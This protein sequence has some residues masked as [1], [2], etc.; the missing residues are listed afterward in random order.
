VVLGQFFWNAKARCLRA[1]TAKPPAVLASG[2]A[3][4]AHY[5][6]NA[7]PHVV[8]STPP[9]SLRISHLATESAWTLRRDTNTA[10]Q[11]TI[12]LTSLSNPTNTTRCIDLKYTTRTLAIF[13]HPD[14]GG[15]ATWHSTCSESRSSR[16]EGAPDYRPAS[17]E[18]I[19][20]H[21]W[22]KC[23]RRKV[24]KGCGRRGPGTRSCTVSKKSYGNQT[25]TC[26][27]QFGS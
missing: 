12:P 15:T 13:P 27:G 20:C 22:Q 6:A 9:Q 17:A 21:V 11:A 19:A 2:A 24:R 1:Q 14:I 4:T 16:E 7:N 26:R 8:T 25:G 10:P 18:T 23:S 5:T 3:R